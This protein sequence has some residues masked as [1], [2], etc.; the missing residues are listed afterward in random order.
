MNNNIRKILLSS[1]RILLAAMLIFQL[2]LYSFAVKLDILDYRDGDTYLE[3]F[4]T[5]I[6][7]D[8]V[9]NSFISLVN[10]STCLVTY[11]YDTG[12]VCIFDI[13]STDNISV[14]V[15]SSGLCDIEAVVGGKGFQGQIWEPVGDGYWELNSYLAYTP[16]TTMRNVVL[17]AGASINDIDVLYADGNTDSFFADISG[18]FWIVHDRDKVNTPADTEDEDD[19]ILGFLKDFWE[20][21]KEILIGLFVPSDGFLE[22]WFNE[23]K[24]AFN[25]KFG[26]LTEFY[27]TLTGFF[28]GI[29]TE[30][31]DNGIFSDP[32]FSDWLSWLRDVITGLVLLLTIYLCYQRIVNM[33]SI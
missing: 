33:I 3:T 8:S 9:Y 28:D 7:A 26:V 27:N 16:G 29:D 30:N 10:S 23:I 20:K 2:S 13:V 14:S 32:L 5:T 25:K 6:I 18:T 4:R 11:S 21:L 19:G 24:D 22:K 15:N 12:N 31:T 1:A 17:V